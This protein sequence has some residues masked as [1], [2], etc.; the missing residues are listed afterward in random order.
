M[1]VPI[2]SR[3]DQMHRVVELLAN[4]GILA[5]AV[6]G[7]A[8]LIKQWQPRPVVPTATQRQPPRPPGPIVGTALTLPGVDFASVDQTLVLVLSTQCHFCADS[9]PFYQRLTTEALRRG[10]TAVVA[11]LPQPVDESRR[12]LA[13]LGVSG[14][15]V[16]QAPLTSVGTRG[17]PTLLL[18]DKSG[19]VRNTWIGRLPSAKESDVLAVLDGGLGGGHE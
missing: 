1:T 4:V 18:V 3:F 6:L 5:V 8:V 17:T 13:G 14:A 12:F 10:R 7:C 15:K 2:R 19:T 16:V 9:G 11:V